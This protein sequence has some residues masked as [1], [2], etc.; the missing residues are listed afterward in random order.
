MKQ[1]KDLKKKLNLEVLNYTNLTHK[2]GKYDMP[3]VYC[4][5]ISNI[6]FLANYSQPSTYFRGKNT[7]VSFFEYDINFDGY[8][9]LW[10]AIYYNR[11]DLLRLYIKRFQGVRYF[12]SPDYSKCGDAPEVE[13]QYRQYKGRVVSLW[14]ETNLEAVVI[15]LISCANRDELGYMLDGVEDCETVAFNAKGPVGDPKQLSIFQDSIKYTVDH[16]KKLKT[17]IVYSATPNISK[18][19][20]IFSYAI[21]AGVKVQIPPNILLMRNALK[22]EC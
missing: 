11:K 4:G 18:I 20:N 2:V 13:N 19:R 1:K 5:E 22:G 14:L 8:K 9:G 17:I 15:P 3:Y 10:N 7:C 12:I 21:D 6:D 16:L